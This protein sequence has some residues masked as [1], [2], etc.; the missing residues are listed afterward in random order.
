MTGIKP[1]P[2]PGNRASQFEAAIKPGSLQFDGVIEMSA[3]EVDA[4]G[5]PP[6]VACERRRRGGAEA[7]LC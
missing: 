3:P 1:H 2:D 7:T 5:K 4:G 6:S